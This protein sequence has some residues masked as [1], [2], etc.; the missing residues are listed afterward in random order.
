MGFEMTPEPQRTYILEL[1]TALGSDAEGFVLAGAQAMKFFLPRARGTRDFDFVLD[2]ISLRGRPASIAGKLRELGYLPLEGARN[3]QFQKTIPNSSEVM[4]IEFMAPE[5]HKRQSDF[6]VDIQDGIHARACTGGTIVLVESDP[7]EISGSLPSGES[8][9][10]SLRVT[11]PHAL[12]MLKCLAMDDRYRNVRG[13]GQAEHDRNEARVHA[14]DLIAIISA[15]ADLPLF[16]SQFDRQFGPDRELDA[17]VHKIAQEYFGSEMA[18]GFL[19]YEEFLVANRPAGDSDQRR[20]VPS[21]LKRAHMLMKCLLPRSQ[22]FELLRECVEDILNNQFTESFLR[23]LQQHG[24]NAIDFDRALPFLP[25]PGSAYGKGYVFDS[26]PS[27][28]AKLDDF[29][30]GSIRIRYRQVIEQLQEDQPELTNRFESMFR[31]T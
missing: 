19:L 4:R 14:A 16:Q 17:R 31:R 20:V 6:R 29:E 12:V 21:E 8:A 7:Y 26:T 1:I 25:W 13:V 24:I 18:P 5:E 27:A 2:T 9:R 15:Q 30:K 22:N 10:V 28:F 23:D 11:R 3:F